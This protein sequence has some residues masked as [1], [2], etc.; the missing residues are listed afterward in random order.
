M[1]NIKDKTKL[2]N[3]FSPYFNP[4]KE[5][6]L[7][8]NAKIKEAFRYWLGDVYPTF[9]MPEDMI[10][11]T[12][13]YHQILILSSCSFDENREAANKMIRWLSVM[14]VEAELEEQDETSLHQGSV[15]KVSSSKLSIKLN[16]ELGS[17]PWDGFLTRMKKPTEYHIVWN[18][19]KTQGIIVSDK[20][21]AYE[22]RK[23]SD[24]N[25][26]TQEGK[27]SLIAVAFC[28]QTAE[29]DCTIQTIEL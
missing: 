9:R 13:G 5:D 12:I 14:M 6:N 7:S 22:A 20:Q 24:T 10:F 11:I 18:G 27:Q 15:L 3:P 25:C 16:G 1:G 29:E 21:L 17:T 23:G 28:E 2:A 4:D 26:F 19:D 8:G